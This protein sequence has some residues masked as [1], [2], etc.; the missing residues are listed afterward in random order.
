MLQYL[1]MK[2]RIFVTDTKGKFL[3]FSVYENELLAP[4]D[5]E[6]LYQKAIPGSLVL[7]TCENELPE[8]GYAFRRVV[9]AE[10]L[11]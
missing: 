3:S 11:Q 1:G 2:D 9:Y 10:P 7:V 6:L 5:G 8:G 4:D